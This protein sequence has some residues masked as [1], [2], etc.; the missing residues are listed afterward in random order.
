MQTTGSSSYEAAIIST[1][2]R[3]PAINFLSGLLAGLFVI[4]LSSLLGKLLKRIRAK[5]PLGAKRT[6]IAF[7]GVGIA[8]ATLSLV[9]GALV[10]YQFVAYQGAPQLTAMFGFIAMFA[11][12][13]IIFWAVGWGL[14]RVL[15]VP[16]R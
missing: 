13:A 7:Y 2:P 9:S 11:G 14:Y 3:P 5:H 4:W 6:G 8:M 16:R 10:T 1:N 12:Y 15:A